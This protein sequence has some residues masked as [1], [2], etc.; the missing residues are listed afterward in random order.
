M[1][2]LGNKSA[3]KHV[4]SI[5][6]C[7]L[8]CAS[9]RNTS[10]QLNLPAGN[11]M[12]NETANLAGDSLSGKD[13]KVKTEDLSAT[14]MR[15]KLSRRAGESVDETLPQVVEAEEEKTDDVFHEALMRFGIQI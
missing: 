2:D 13:G 7:G 15:A 14:T 6:E 12:D 3:P 9:T 11:S 8:M 4:D 10:F 5:Y 1:Y